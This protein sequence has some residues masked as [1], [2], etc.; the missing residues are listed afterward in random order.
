MS[1]PASAPRRLS[2]HGI[3]IDALTEAA[4]GLIGRSSMIDKTSFLAFLRAR[5]LMQGRWPA[6]LSALRRVSLWLLLGWVS[7]G[8]QVVIGADS[9]VLITLD[10][11]RWQEL[12]RGLDSRLASDD[13]Y[14]AQQSELMRQ[15]WDDDPAE[16]ARLLFPF[17]HD[18]VFEQG[19]V[20]GNRDRGSCARVANPWYF[21]YPGYSEILTGV[22]NETI[23]SNSKI[24]NPERTVHELLEGIDGFVGRTAAFASWDV[25]PFIFNVERSGVYVNAFEPLNAPE[26]M[27]EITLNRLHSDIPPPWPTVRNDAFT[28]R[29]ALS[30]LRREQ[31][32]LLFISYGE[33]DDFAHD[34]KYDEY[35]FAANRTDRFIEEVWHTLQSIPGYRDNTALVITVDHGRGEEPIETWLHH[36]SKRSL[37]G[38]MSSLS[39]FTEGIIGSEG[40][41]IAAIGS[42]VA[43]KGLIVTEEQCAFS[44]QVASTLVELLGL[45][46][47]AL[48]PEMAP[49]LSELLD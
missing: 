28:H 10:G 47:Q 14:S 22:V 24:P 4:A 23:N 17:L 37:D 1:A 26:G 48:N 18:T 3:F 41:W 6:P 32:R 5:S 33:T 43:G 45:D 40:T 44:S 39:H 35:L 30:Y 9:V 42:G 15:F 25:F 7:S 12:F 16:R 36:A 19:S 46:P 13:S 49:P 27:E 38:Y 11:L 2:A 8:Q 20:I 21:S 29:Y 31:P 34:G